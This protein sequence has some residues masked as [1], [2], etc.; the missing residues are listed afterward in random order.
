MRFLLDTHIF[1]WL[2]LNSD[3]LSTTIREVVANKEND[4]FLSVVSLWEVI[5]K[6]KKGSLALPQSAEIYIPFYRIQHEINNLPITENAVIQLAHL[7]NIH[8]DPFDRMLVAQAIQ[9]NLTL[10]TVDSNIL[11]YPVSCLKG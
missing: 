9:Y 6:E 1:L 11:Q 5:I 8:K 7:P 10:I 2:I 4:V 3:R